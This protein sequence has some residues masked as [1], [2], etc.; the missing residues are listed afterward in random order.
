MCESLLTLLLFEQR[1]E[2]KVNKHIFLEFWAPH[3]ILRF[4]V[5]MDDVQRMH[6]F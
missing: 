1:G 3:H 2:T 6:Q 5:S 4:D